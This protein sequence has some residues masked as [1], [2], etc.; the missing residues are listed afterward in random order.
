M[1][2]LL[3]PDKFK[4]TLTARQ[5]AEAFETG[6]LRS[7][8]EDLVELL[9]LADGGEGT[10]DALAT[11]G[12][13]LTVRVTGP[14]GDPVDAEL[15]ILEQGTAIVESARA[16]GLQ[17]LSLERRDP[18]RTTTRGVGEL[19]L[20]AMDEGAERVLVCLGGSATNDG[21]A[22]MAAALGVSFTNAEGEPIAPG[23]AG[24]ID[25]AHVDMRDLDPRLAKT[26]VVGLT[27][28]DNR[29]CGPGG[30]SNTYAPQKGAT[31]ADV[32]LLDRALMHL[33]AVVQKDTGRYVSDDP[34]A[35]AA[36]GLGFGLM[37]FCGARLRPGFEAVA[38]AVSLERRAAAADL[39]VTGEGALD[40]TS[41]RGK[42]VGGVLRIAQLAGTRAVIVCGRA[43]V[44]PEGVEVVSLVE[45][46]GEERAV[47]D[48]RA[49]LEEAA[50]ALAG[51]QP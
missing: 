46:A 50:Q 41:L 21:G 48:P 7:R 10:L 6:W 12:R 20:A 49:S 9:P 26:E 14:L 8:P 40:A 33:D 1:R 15:G 2:V 22:G 3:C 42:V 43:D 37:V 39:V 19:I 16:A 11:E 17:L 23:G 30:A 28:V 13:R 35:G 45:E 38:E 47:N 25:L 27:D 51:R 36:G 18:K 5:A 31:L 24:L 34:G 44:R 29:L 4:G 32:A